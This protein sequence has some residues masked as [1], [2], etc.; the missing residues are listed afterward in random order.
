MDGTWVRGEKMKDGD[1]LED[2][3][4]RTYC[5]EQSPS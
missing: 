5:M 4:F 3:S 2:L 1:N